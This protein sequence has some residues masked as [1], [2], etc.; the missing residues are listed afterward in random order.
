MQLDR[1]LVSAHGRCSRRGGLDA[2]SNA[3]HGDRSHDEGKAVEHSGGRTRRPARI[4][5]SRPR[6]DDQ[7]HR[8]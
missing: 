6:R 3:R 5:T 7:Q 1:A 8:K 4:Q 2:P